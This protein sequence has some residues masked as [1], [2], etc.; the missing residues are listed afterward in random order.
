MSFDTAAIRARFPALGRTENGAPVAHLDGPGG[1]QV[2]RDVIDAMAGVLR[3]GISNLGGTF[4]A[5]REAAEIVGDARQAAADL[6]GAEPDEIVFGPNMTSLTFALSRGIGRT[7]GPG[8]RILTTSLDHDANRA[9]WRAIAADRGAVVN[10]VD[11]DPLSGILDPAEVAAAIDQDTVLVAVTAAS[12]ALGSVTDLEPVIAAAHR[13]GAL[14]YV[15][16]VHFAPHRLLDVHRS[17]ADFVAVSAYKFFG[18]HL[19]MVYGRRDR[20]DASIP[21]KVGP[22]PDAAPDRWE[23]GTQSFEALAGITAVVDYL[24]SLG[25]GHGR[26]ER[27]ESA[28]GAIREHEGR[29]SEQFLTGLSEMPGVALHGPGL[30]VGDRVSTFAVTVEGHDPAAVSRTLGAQGIYTWHGHYYAD[31]VM[32]RLGLADSGGAVRIGFVH[33]TVPEEVDRVLEALRS[34]A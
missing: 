17:G 27:L 19:A 11:F 31:G 23:T 32:Q 1:T 7:W 3:R 2:P 22:A 13:V 12:N 8:S 14:V 26:R 10:E 18:P 25:T 28:F 16:A 20:L 6:L 21:Y 34:L 9:P 33:Y 4:A 29:L 24:A 5:S 15:D 30:G